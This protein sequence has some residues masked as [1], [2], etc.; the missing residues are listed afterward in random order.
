MKEI[1]KKLQNGE[2]TI[3]EAEDALRLLTIEKIEDLA[4]LDVSRELR[5]GVPE[6]IY[7]QSKPVEAIQ[8]ITERV[9]TKRPILIISRVK[10]PDIQSL[11]QQLEPK[12]N[13]ITSNHSSTLVVSQR[14]YQPVLNSGV[15]GIISAGTSDI[16][17]ADEVRIVSETMG[18]KTYSAYDIGVAGIHRLFPELKNM[19]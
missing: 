18:C 7:G 9:L 1:L 16:P 19:I 17:V 2:L 12:Y 8:A 10:K 3:K 15:V 14:N 11:V 13:V 4:Q 6:I 5:K